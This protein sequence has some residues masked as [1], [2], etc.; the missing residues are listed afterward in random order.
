[1]AV[2]EAEREITPRA[3]EI[4]TQFPTRQSRLRVFDEQGL[5]LSGEEAWLMLPEPD[6]HPLLRSLF[7]VVIR[8]PHAGASR[9]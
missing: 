7:N 4:L 2:L 9:S 8:F 1:M 5:P 6:E 3:E